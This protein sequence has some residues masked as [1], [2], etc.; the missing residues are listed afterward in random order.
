MWVLGIEPRALEEQPVLLS[1]EPS[2]QPHVTI[3]KEKQFIVKSRVFMATEKEKSF[4]F[5]CLIFL[6]KDNLEKIAKMIE[7][8]VF[9]W[10]QKRLEPLP[11][12]YCRTE[13]LRPV[14]RPL[15]ATQPSSSSPANWKH[16]VDLKLRCRP[17]VHIPA[18]STF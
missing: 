16:T 9:P 8:K 2:S 5:N 6:P 3:L 11:S 18:A 14:P 12:Q 15:E 13:Q 7:E 10:R 1:A 4:F 17:G